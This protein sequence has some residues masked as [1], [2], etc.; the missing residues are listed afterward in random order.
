MLKLFRVQIQ[1]GLLVV[2]DS[3]E[4]PL[5]QIPWSGTVSSL[6]LQLFQARNLI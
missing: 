4:S 5:L 1:H 6:K 2:L 3:N